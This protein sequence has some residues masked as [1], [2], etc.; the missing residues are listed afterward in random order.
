M[1]IRKLESTKR[2]WLAVR[3]FAINPVDKSEYHIDSNPFT[4]IA[5]NG[6]Q[7]VALDGVARSILLMGNVAD[8]S[9]RLVAADGS[10]VGEG[11]S[12]SSYVELATNGATA[13]EICGNCE[14]IEVVKK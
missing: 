9:Y 13:I 10:V 2:N 8:A 4:K 6:V 14:I 5:I 11:A 12:S 7:S 3:E 1:G